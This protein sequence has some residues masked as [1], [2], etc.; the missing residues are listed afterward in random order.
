MKLRPNIE[1]IGAQAIDRLDVIRDMGRM[2]GATLAGTVRGSRPAGEVVNQLHIMGNRSLFFVAITL[3]FV[4]MVLI[5]Q[6]GLQVERIGLVSAN[7]IGREFIK[8]LI[9]DLGPTLTGLMLATR[10][11]AGI[12]AEIGSMKVTEQIDALRMSGVRPID[13]LIVPRF[14]AGIVMT[15]VLSIM[16]STIAYIAGGLTAMSSFDVPSEVFFDLDLVNFTHLGLF[17]AKAVS[18]G[19][20]IPL[21]AGFCG[22]RAQGSS[23]GV[24]WAT[25]AAVVGG[26]FVVLLLDFIISAVGLV[27][28]GE[29]L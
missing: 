5:Y 3:G 11:G 20:A 15:L 25:T 28:F 27:I 17:I 21:V 2:F 26:S 24:G 10:V 23:E 22:L 14:I 4:G 12:A 6:V 9:H 13:Y 16:G 7:P 29:G 19:M 8:L 18:Y 1:R